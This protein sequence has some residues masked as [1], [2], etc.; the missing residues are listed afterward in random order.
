MEGYLDCFVLQPYCSH[1]ASVISLFIKGL[2]N[3]RGARISRSSMV[4]KHLTDN[5]LFVF[6]TADKQGFFLLFPKGLLLFDL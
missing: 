3:N 6:H 1:S 4:Q 5:L 2:Y